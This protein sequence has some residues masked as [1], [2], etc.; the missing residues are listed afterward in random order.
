VPLFLP[1]AGALVCA[2]LLVV[3]LSSSDWHAP[4]L[5]AAILL[6]C[7]AIFAALQV[8]KPVSR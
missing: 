4:A 1:A 8:A 5:A 3:R 6:V 2:G 7:L